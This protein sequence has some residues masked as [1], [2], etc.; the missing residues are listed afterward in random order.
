MS[1]TAADVIVPPNSSSRS[2][3]AGTIPTIAMFVGTARFATYRWR[4]G[5]PYFDDLELLLWSSAGW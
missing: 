1:M 4:Y 2:R 5:L 3:H